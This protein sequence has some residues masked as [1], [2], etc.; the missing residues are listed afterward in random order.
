M[1]LRFAC[2]AAVLLFGFASGC[3]ATCQKACCMISS[4]EGVRH[5]VVFKFKEGTSDAQ[6]K[7]I[8]DEFRKLPSKIPGITGFEWGRNNSPE[9]LDQGFTHIFLVT[10]RDAASRDA[11]LPHP[12]HKNFVKIL[13]PHLEKPFVVDYDIQE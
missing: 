8:V 9:G 3:S 10:F 11:Y 6:L 5:V 4:T 13:G 7:T 1:I 2:A 12:A